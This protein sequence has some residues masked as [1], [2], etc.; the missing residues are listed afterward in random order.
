LLV[1]ALTACAV[2]TLLWMVGPASASA[3]VPPGFV[4]MNADG[5][6]FDKSV[7]FQRQLNTMVSSGV[8]NLRLIFNWSTAQPYKDYNALNKAGDD[9]ANF[10]NVNG[11]PTRYFDILVYLAAQ[12]GL[13]VLPDVL[14]TPKWDALRHPHV[15]HAFAR[16]ARFGP[17]QNFLRALVKR[18]GPQ[19][20]FW[21]E[22]PELPY[23]PI[24]MWQIWNEPSIPTWW[25]TRPWPR[26]FVSFMIAA[27]TAV[28]QANRSAKVVLPGLP[29]YSWIYLNAMYKFRGAKN[30]FDVVA[31]HPYTATPSGVIT[32]LSH[33][34]DVMNKHGDG[35]KAILATEVGWPSSLHKGYGNYGTTEGGQ[36]RDI[37]QVLPMLARARGRLRLLGFDIYTWIGLE[38]QHGRAFD[39]SGL[40]RDTPQ[41]KVFAKPAFGAF[42]NGALRMEKCH[43][44]GPLATHCRS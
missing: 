42:R 11:V 21:S 12:H 30:A 9:P 17:F 20:E 44:K 19:G 39:Y 32:I 6:I 2:A 15:H 16:P 24:T 31:V 7:N 27:H 10:A 4:G 37:G 36:A 22:H 1:Q 28:K 34:R 29:N 25:P 26:S 23:R 43:S 41:G 8:E 18:Y 3:R 35:R 5:P 14:F 40:L 13:R 33:V 38:R